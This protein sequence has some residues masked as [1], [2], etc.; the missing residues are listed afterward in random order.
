MLNLNL[1]PHCDRKNKKLHTPQK[2]SRTAKTAIWVR[3]P[4]SPAEPVP[5]PGFLTAHSIRPTDHCLVR[6]LQWGPVPCINNPT[7]C[8]AL[9]LLIL[10]MNPRMAPC[11]NLNYPYLQTPHCVTYWSS[12]SRH[13]QE[14]Y[15]SDAETEKQ[16]THC[17][18]PGH[19]HDFYCQQLKDWRLIT[20]HSI[21]LFSQPQGS[22]ESISLPSHAEKGLLFTRAIY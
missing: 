8:M 4:T 15:E 13:L 2:K 21:H 3:F 11:I 5:L 1:K 22:T 19:K 20:A 12:A 9:V 7:G 6:A 10:R 17:R 14:T 18:G 16:T